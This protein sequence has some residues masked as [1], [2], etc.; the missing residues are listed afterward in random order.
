[1]P[2]SAMIFFVLFV[3][4]LVGAYLVM[5]RG[6]MPS[7]WATAAA[8]LGAIISMTLFALAQGNMMAQALVVGLVI[9]GGFSIIF[10]L[11]ARFFHSQQ[12]NEG[13]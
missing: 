13:R 6:A 1:M 5:R 9:G 2:I 10:L 11:M 3:A 4:I 7:R 8:V 12:Q